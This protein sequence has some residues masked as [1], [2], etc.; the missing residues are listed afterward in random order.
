MHTTCL[1]KSSLFIS[2]YL[3]ASY[4][5]TGKSLMISSFMLLYKVLFTKTKNF[6]I[7]VNSNSI[8]RSEMKLVD[9]HVSNNCAIATN[10]LFLAPQYNHTMFPLPSSSS[11]ISVSHCTLKITVM[12]VMLVTVVSL[13]DVRHTK[14]TFLRILFDYIFEHILHLCNK[15]KVLKFIKIKVPNCFVFFHFKNSRVQNI[16]SYF[17]ILHLKIR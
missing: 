16:Q 8:V 4:K 5:L 14:Q 9:C 17:K 11:Q 6:C 7:K 3:H 10:N 15:I 13:I 2:R 12:L 1:R